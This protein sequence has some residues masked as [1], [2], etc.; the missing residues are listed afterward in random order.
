MA[1]ILFRPIC[2]KC[3]KQLH[4][5]IDCKEETIAIDNSPQFMYDKDYRITPECCP[6]C[7]EYFTSIQM[8]TS[9]PFDN[10]LL[11]LSERMNDNE[12]V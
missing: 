2:S 4:L 9:V 10:S 12:T 7:K 8:P 1:S 11:L 6:Y 3:G 5:L